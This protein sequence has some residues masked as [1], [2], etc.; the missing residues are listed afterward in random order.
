MFHI[1]VEKVPFNLVLLQDKAKFNSNNHHDIKN[2]PVDY[3]LKL[4]QTN[5]KH[6]VKQFHNNQSYQTITLNESEVKILEKCTSI[7]DLTGKI[8]ALF[9]E[10]IDD[11]IY[12][13][14]RQIRWNNLGY[15]VRAEDVSL[16]Y[17]MYGN[18][19][20]KSMKTIVES[21]ITCPKNHRCTTSTINLYFLPW[22]D[23]NI[24]LEF[25]VFVHNNEITAISQQH[26][27]RQNQTL[28]EDNISYYL[29]LIIDYFYTTIV[30]KITHIES[31]CVDICVLDEPYFIEIN[32]FGKEYSSGSALFHWLHDE[33]I[34]YGKKNA[35]II[36]FRFL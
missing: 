25:R 10:D 26:C 21:I 18:I 7:Y 9:Q 27:Y 15:F 2:P 17:G 36:Y 30:S 8:S 13:Y 20:H 24:D 14:N 11:I 19:P 22:N 1:S 35:S 16:K 29:N 12:K 6:W 23:I 5:T 4:K 32:P 34:L 28:H 3:E 33:D 31:Y